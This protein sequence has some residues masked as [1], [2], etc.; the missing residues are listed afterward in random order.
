MEKIIEKKNSKQYIYVY[1]Y[2]IFICIL[3]EIEIAQKQYWDVRISV[4]GF[5]AH[6]MKLSGEL[7]QLKKGQ[8]N[9]SSLEMKK[10]MR[11][12]Q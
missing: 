11:S 5:K 12:S 6:I 4:L 8:T 1:N 3:D 9:D 7:D 10:V 2:Q